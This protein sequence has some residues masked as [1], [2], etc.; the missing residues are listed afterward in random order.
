MAV[1]GRD[2]TISISIELYKYIKCTISAHTYL[3]YIYRAQCMPHTTLSLT[4]I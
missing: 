2:K 4:Y 3:M 1:G